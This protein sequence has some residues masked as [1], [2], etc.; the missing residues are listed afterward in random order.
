MRASLSADEA[1]G[2][3]LRTQHFGDADVVEPIDLLDRLSAIQMDSVNILARNHLLVPFARLGPYSI[4][5]LYDAIYKDKRGFEYWGHMASWLPMAEYR[6][7]LPRMTRMRDTGRGWWLRVR[8]E[9]AELYPLVLERVR[10]EGPL[11]AAAFDDPRGG[12]GTWWDWKPAKLVLEDLLDQGLLMCRAR[13][14]G[15]ARLYDLTERV[16]P[17]GLDAS[18]PGQLAATQHLLKRGLDRLGVA[19]AIEMADYF[20]LRPADQVKVGLAGLL[21]DGQIVQT[22]VE[23]WGKPAYTTQA[24]LN[25]PLSVPEHRPTFLA[26]FDN[27]LWERQRVERI[28]GFHYRVEIYVPEPKRQYGYFVLPLLVRGGLRGRADLKLD[29]K[30]S[31]LQVRGL[32]LEGA[33]PAEAK[34]ALEDL[35]G[36]LG[37]Q[38]LDLPG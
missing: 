29:R 11:G 37:A 7:F 8:A 10:A 12:R 3:A 2:L 21:A 13:T 16:L 19:T 26:P 18:D 5:A 38:E 31:V 17:A 36:H 28:F 23:G 9:H 33:Q 30:A 27:L 25:G 14:A 4:Q 22:D 34:V 32:W 24:L 1:R 35:A 6:Y 20:R 15:F